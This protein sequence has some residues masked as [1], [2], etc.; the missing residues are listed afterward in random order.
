[1]SWQSRCLAARSALE[2]IEQFAREAKLG[3]VLVLASRGLQSSE[4]TEEAKRAAASQ[5]KR[6][7]RVTHTGV[8]PDSHVKLLVVTE[9]VGGGLSD[10]E[11]I[12]SRSIEVGESEGE[13]HTGITRDSHAKPKA[14]RERKSPTTPLPPEGQE[15]EWAVGWGIPFEHPEFP[16]FILGHRKKDNRWV[17]WKS[18][19]GQWLL[20]V[21][22]Y[23]RPSAPIG[24]VDYEA[25]KRASAAKERARRAGPE[26]VPVR[27]DTTTLPAFLQAKA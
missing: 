18:A 5:R 17:N 2:T 10:L 24:A 11:E 22:L 4:D 21:P 12:T 6:K 25:M 3:A 26:E 13:G 27:L 16:N 7:G 9:G 1:M 19:W 15:R 8:T 23:A 14:K 20:H